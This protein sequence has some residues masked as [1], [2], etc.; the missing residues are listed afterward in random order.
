M[1]VLVPSWVVHEGDCL[2]VLKTLADDS[3]VGV[4][5]DPPYS[6]GGRQP[7]SAR[8]TLS[9]NG[10]RED[11]DWFLGDNMGSDT[12]LWWMRE[13]ARECLRIAEPGSQAHVF[14]DWRQYTTLNNAWES[15]GW[16]LRSVLVWDKDRGGA[17]GSFWRNNHEW[18]CIYVK[19]KPKD[20]PHFSFFNTWRGA[21]PQ[22]GLHPTQKPVRLMRYLCSAHVPKPGAL[23]DP[24]TGSGT[25]GVAALLEGFSFVG[26][27]REPAFVAESRKRIAEAAQVQTAGSTKL[28]G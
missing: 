12:Y 16:T 26:I 10:L 23:L 14:T 20:L 22:G 24:F 9:K 28:V 25:T 6:S 3:V 4:V 11:E 13:I 7:T 1:S 8:N 21:K 5:T 19:G 2:D 17:M 18:T 15:V 27:E